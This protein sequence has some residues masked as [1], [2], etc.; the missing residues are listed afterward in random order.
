VVPKF[1]VI[2]V[3]YNSTDVFVRMLDSLP[4]NVP[5]IAVDNGSADIERL[6]AMSQSRSFM[7]L[8]NEYNL[9]FGVAC[10][11]GAHHANT[12]FLLFLNPDAK[13]TEGCLDEVFSAFSSYPNCVALNPAIIDSNGKEYFRRGSVLL[14]KSLWLPRGWP[15]EDRTVNILSGSALFTR[16]TVFDEIG[17]FDEHIFLYHEDDD[18][19]LRISAYG[20]LMFIKNAKVEHSGGRSSPRS[21]AVAALKALHMGR[22]RV[23]A[24]RKHKVRFPVVKPLVGAFLQLCSPINIF[25]HRKRAKSVAFLNGII[26]EALR[27]S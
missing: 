17:G 2:T 23:Y 5:V 11:R 13:L 4:L 18:L 15:T 1:T 7:L 8:E 24:G 19:S 14:N 25:S 9:G 3:T 20:D 10:N 22:S 12:E 26:V 16:K 21:P 6:R 27:R